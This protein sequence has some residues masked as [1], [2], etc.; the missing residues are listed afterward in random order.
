MLCHTHHFVFASPNKTLLTG[1][2]FK[3][4]TA[5]TKRQ[6]YQIQHVIALQRPKNGYIG[7]KKCIT[8]PGR[9][10]FPQTYQTGFRAHP[11]SFPTGSGF[12][13]GSKQAKREADRLRPPSS[14][15]TNEW[16]YTCTPPIYLHGVDSD[17]CTFLCEYRTYTF[18]FEGN[19]RRSELCRRVDT[20]GVEPSSS[21][22]R[23]IICTSINLIWNIRT[24]RTRS[25]ALPL[26]YQIIY[27][28]AHVITYPH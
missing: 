1:Y 24:A 25:Q 11:A 12:F 9:E 17:N 6:C 5:I 8:N 13:P 19:E 18:I 3:L 14:K 23:D 27:T 15:V 22:A 20:C 10:T 26:C 4:V 21:V 7:Y 28:L 16:S 2:L